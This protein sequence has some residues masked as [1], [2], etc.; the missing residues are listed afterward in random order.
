MSNTIYF[1]EECKISFSKVIIMKLTFQSRSLKQTV[2]QQ[3]SRYVKWHLNY[4]TRNVQRIL[5]DVLEFTVK[6]KII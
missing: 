3:T 1:C 5:T 4:N 6:I 2:P